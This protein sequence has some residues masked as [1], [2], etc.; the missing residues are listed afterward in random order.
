MME[1]VQE[2]KKPN[3][4]KEGLIYGGESKAAKYL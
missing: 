4:E 1:R 2:K 3:N